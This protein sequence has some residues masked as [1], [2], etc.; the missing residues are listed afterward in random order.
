LYWTDCASTA[1]AHYLTAVLNSRVVNDAIKEFQSRGL[2]G[3]RDIEKKALELPFPAYDGK[4]ERHRSLADLGAEAEETARAR[5]DVG[6]MP[7][8][9]GARRDA[10]REH[11]GSILDEIELVGDLVKLEN[12]SEGNERA[13]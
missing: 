5:L 10:M 8:G 7:K 1:E 3:E 9:L 13:E 11:L 12:A 2:G 6:D 4:K